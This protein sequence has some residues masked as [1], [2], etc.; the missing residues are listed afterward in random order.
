LVRKR[1]TSDRPFLFN[2][3]HTIRFL[4][5]DNSLLEEI[6]NSCFAN[7]FS[8]LLSF[9]PFV[10]VESEQLENYGLLVKG[11]KQI[12]NGRADVSILCK[13]LMMQYAHTGRLDPFKLFNMETV[14]VILD[15]M[16]VSRIMSAFPPSIGLS[17]NFDLDFCEEIWSFNYTYAPFIDRMD[18]TQKE[19]EHFAEAKMDELTIEFKELYTEFKRLNLLAVY[20]KYIAEVNMGFVARICNLSLDVVDFVKAHK[21]EIAELTHRTII[22]TVIVASWL[23][24][25]RDVELYK[26][27]REYSTGR[28]RFFAEKFSDMAANTS[29]ED[30]AKKLKEVVGEEMGANHINVATERGDIFDLRIDQMAE[31]VWG[32]DHPYYFHYKRMSEVTHGHWRVIAK[33]HLSKSLNPMHN[34]LYLYNEN[35]NR[36]AGLVPAF[37]CLGMSCQFLARVLADINSDDT[38][39]LAAKVIA[40]DKKIFDGYMSYFNKYIAIKIDE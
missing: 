19:E 22:E 12:L 39:E 8:E 11:F 7:A 37:V 17:E 36:F 32:K 4:K 33:Y 40:L 9:Y 18:D 30:Q 20:T 38:K 3:S 31:A 34:G 35:P 2:L 23:L 27:F 15:P 24:S 26:R 14:E 21:A 13:Y 1:D 25:K 28:E 5:T 6:K 16:N 29:M 10:N